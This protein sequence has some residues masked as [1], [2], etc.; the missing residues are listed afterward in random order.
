[1][2][3]KNLPVPPMPEGWQ[4]DL[5][6]Q[7]QIEAAGES[8]M[9]SYLS[10]KG[11]MLSFGGK[12]VPD[13]RMN[14]IILETVF[15]RSF[16][17]R[18]YNP[19]EFIIPECY[20]IARHE[21][22]L[23]PHE[24]AVNKHGKN[25]ATCPLSQWESDLKGG[26]GQACKSRRRLAFINAAVLEQGV[27]GILN[28]TVYG[29]KVPP[30]STRNW[31]TFV[32]S[33]ANVVKRPPFGVATTVS[34]K[35]HPKYLYEL[36]FGYDELVPEALLPVVLAKKSQLGETFM[37]PWPTEKEKSEQDKQHEEKKAQS[38]KDAAKRAKKY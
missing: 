21:E 13:N 28:A 9:T 17:P 4:E 29:L 23:V 26:K 8:P 31:G 7:A 6:R 32:N 1:M 12:P 19:E 35:P 38:G 5:A 2:T 10:T 36:T 22:D 34:C 16:D 14:I 3:T 11:G 24:R 27:E 25:C 37:V 33:L 20:A 30:T 15:E 18:P